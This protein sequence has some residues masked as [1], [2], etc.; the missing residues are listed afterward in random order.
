MRLVLLILKLKMMIRRKKMTEKINSANT[1][2]QPL[3]QIL[4]RTKAG[5]AKT[6][7]SVSMVL[8]TM[9]NSVISF[10]PQIT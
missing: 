9:A 2:V 7:A 10:A 5:S 8:I 4:K 3:V 1:L 6:A